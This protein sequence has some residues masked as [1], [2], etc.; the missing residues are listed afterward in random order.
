MKTTRTLLLLLLM[1]VFCAPQT[2]ANEPYFFED[3][4]GFEGLPNQGII[5]V[6]DNIIFNKE[7]TP[8]FAYEF[9]VHDNA[10][11]PF[12]GTFGEEPA[13]KKA[14]L[15]W[16]LNNGKIQS[17]SWMV[18]RQIDLTDADNPELTFKYACGLYIGMRDFS[19]KI[20]EEFDGLDPE[21]SEWID[22]T[23]ESGMYDIMPFGVDVW[24]NRLS[25]LRVDLSPYAGK[26]IYIAFN[27]KT[28]YDLTNKN[29]NDA[30]IYIDDVKVA[31]KPVLAPGVIYKE[32]FTDLPGPHSADF[33]GYNGWWN[34]KSSETHRY[35]KKRMD[36]IV[37]KPHVEHMVWVNHTKMKSALA[38]LISPKID[39]RNVNDPE[40][41]FNFGIGNHNS[42]NRFLKIKITDEFEGGAADPT[43]SIW[44]D[45]TDL[46]GIYNENIV[47]PYSEVQP[48]S[49]HNVKVDLSDYKGQGIYICFEYHMPAKEDGTTYTTDAPV[50]YIDEVKVI[51]KKKSSLPGVK[52]DHFIKVLKDRILVSDDVIFTEIY[53]T[54]GKLVRSTSNNFV[55]VDD[56]QGV[57]LV[58]VNDGSRSYTFKAVL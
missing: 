21:G 50:Y 6:T 10:L 41:S 37:H 25:D 23:E 22:V 34:G 40:L 1:C 39:L 3:F 48:E 38:W 9:R 17:D 47:T 45:I 14:R 24:P 12:Y 20:T 42:T 18:T 2:K 27:A 15:A 30:L 58:R 4:E 49:F 35:F 51:D 54:D 5:P 26:K 8:H 16:Y 33:T 53:S 36:T 57:Y 55:Q 44:E 46:T 28:P 52:P 43:Q 19:V 7:L 13:L 29:P 31:E 56:L 11:I 32:S